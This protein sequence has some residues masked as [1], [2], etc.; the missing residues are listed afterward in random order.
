MW[1][2]HTH[3]IEALNKYTCL[4]KL[5]NKTC[6]REGM[7]GYVLRTMVY[8]QRSRG[9]QWQSTVRVL[10]IVHLGG[11][12][13]YMVRDEA[14]ETTVCHASEFGLYPKNDSEPLKGMC[15]LS[16]VPH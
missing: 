3:H 13:R 11:P 7:G 4:P 2:V 9:K 15:H 10:Q 6:E 12:S 5:G 8:E 16:S 14:K 1:E